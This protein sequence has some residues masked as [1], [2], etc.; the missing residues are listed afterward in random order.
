MKGGEISTP[1]MEIFKVNINSDG[2][3]DK[4]KTRI[5]V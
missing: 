3:S 2:S 5:V 1:V 4:L